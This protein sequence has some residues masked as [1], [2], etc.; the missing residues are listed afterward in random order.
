M[1]SLRRRVETFAMKRIFL[2]AC[3]VL[4]ASPAL[5]QKVTI[6]GVDCRRLVQHD[7]APDVAYKPGVDARGRPVAPADLNAAPQIKVPETITFD[8]A[9]DLRRFGIP[10]SSPLFEP[11]VYVGR[12]DVRQDGRVY[13]NGERLGDPEIAALE[14]LCRQ[15][16]GR[17]A[18]R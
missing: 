4:A 16:A 15:S 2:A 10:A 7:P 3:L 11:N 5:A 13:F 12:V 8:A 9:A 1:V 17:A 14:E 6:S 18:P